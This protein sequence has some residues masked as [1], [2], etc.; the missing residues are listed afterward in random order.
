MERIGRW[1]ETA[2][3][4]AELTSTR[5]DDLDDPLTAHA[6]ARAESTAELLAAEL[7]HDGLPIDVASSGGA[8]S[9]R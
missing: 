4:A 7:E 2:W 9:R 5:L 6:T 3:R 8:A 1:A